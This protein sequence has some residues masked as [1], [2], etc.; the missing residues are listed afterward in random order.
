MLPNP[1]SGFGNGEVPSVLV[2]KK[3][4]VLSDIL[5]EGGSLG[6]VTGHGKKQSFIE[7]NGLILIWLE[8]RKLIIP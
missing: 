3:L 4:N 6:I 8:V 2:L 5:S 7:F 1:V